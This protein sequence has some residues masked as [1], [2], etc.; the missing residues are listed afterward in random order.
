MSNRKETARRDAQN[1]NTARGGAVWRTVATKRGAAM[2]SP[3]GR[4]FYGTAAEVRDAALTPW[5]RSSLAQSLK[6]HRY[7][8]DCG[9]FDA[10]DFAECCAH[11]RREA[12]ATHEAI[13]AYVRIP[14]DDFIMLGAAARYMERTPDEFLLEGLRASIDAVRDEADID[15]LSDI[16]L[17]R[18]EQ[19][20]LERIRNGRKQ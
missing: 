14:A 12:I 2:R 1:T 15:G 7:C 6:L 13:G 18:H 4:L 10:A 16:P 9:T 11:R 17:T 5:L 20:A 8:R 3:D 19:S